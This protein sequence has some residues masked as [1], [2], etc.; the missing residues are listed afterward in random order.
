MPAC[1]ACHNAKVSCDQK[2]PSCSRCLK[3]NIVCIPRI[4]RQGQGPKKRKRSNV[5]ITK[6]D[7]LVASSEDATLVKHDFGGQHH[8][9][10]R[11][12]I[13]SWISFAFSR[14][15]FSLLS[16][17]SRLAASANIDMD[18]ILN[19]QRRP[20]LEPLM[21]NTNDSNS[22]TDKSSSASLQWLDLPQRLRHVCAISDTPSSNFQNRYIFVREADRGQSRYLTTDAFARDICSSY[23]MQQTWNANDK[24]VTQLFLQEDNFDKFTSAINYHMM[25]YTEPNKAPENLRVKSVHVVF[26]NGGNQHNTTTRE[27]DMIYTFEIVDLEQSFYVCEF[28]PSKEDVPT[29]A[30]SMDTR[31]QDDTTSQ[32]TSHETRNNPSGEIQNADLDPIPLDGI[33]DLFKGDELEAFLDYIQ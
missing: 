23:V 9:G 3:R 18:A 7:G 1:T 17:A 11:Y 12:M 13:Y 32:S 4:S 27:M 8:Y 29:A 25:R 24:P 14:R 10:V 5:N 31:A 26:G 19:E 28:V 2:L 21:W 33:A 30:K 20:F 22:K 15:S 16:R 6:N